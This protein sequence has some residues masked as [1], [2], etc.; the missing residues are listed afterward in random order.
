M[1]ESAIRPE[2]KE[3]VLDAPSHREYRNRVRGTSLS[4]PL[5]Y[6]SLLKLEVEWEQ[7]AVSLSQH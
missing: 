7:H 3:S 5:R 6:I 2:P 1:M 4:L